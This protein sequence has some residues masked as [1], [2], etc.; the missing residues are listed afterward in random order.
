[1]SSS[2]GS[3]A[4]SRLTIGSVV[5]GR[6]EIVG[7]IGQ[8]GMGTVY[9]ARQIKLDK[10][11]ALKVLQS[12]R[13]LRDDDGNSH[14][15]FLR[16]ARVASAIHH[17]NVVDI[18]DFGDLEDGSTYYVMELL[19]GRDLASIL[20]EEGPLA[21]G[22]VRPLLRQVL[23][24]LGAAHR[25][26][27]IHRDVKPANIMVLDEPDEWG[28]PWVKV[29]D[30]GIARV[31]T[32]E[33]DSQ[34]LTGTS[35]LLGTAAY[36]GPELAK[37]ERADARTDLYALGIVAYQLLTGTVP[38]QAPNAFQ[39]LLR[40]MTDLPR[41]PRELEPSIPSEVEAFV[42]QSLEKDREHR[43][44]SAAEMAARL[45]EL[46]VDEASDAHRRGPIAARSSEPAGA[47]GVM[48]AA[49]QARQM[50]ELY[51]ARPPG[52]DARRDDGVATAK[53]VVLSGSSSAGSRR[54]PW[55]AILAGVGAVVAVVLWLV[56][57]A[58]DSRS[59]TTPPGSRDVAGP[60]D[61]EPPGAS[62]PAEVVAAS[63]ADA[64]AAGGTTGADEGASGASSHVPEASSGGT[65]EAGSGGTPEAGTGGDEGRGDEP[66]PSSEAEGPAKC[67]TPACLHKAAETRLRRAVR[68]R[69]RSLG[70]GEVV[71]VKLTIGTDGRVLMPRVLEPHDGTALGKCVVEEVAK[72]RFPPPSQLTPTQLRLKP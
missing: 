31:Q 3:L 43:F 15:R 24:A 9:E 71:T 19:K 56:L 27:V 32:A 20:K 46:D 40:H 16:E 13:A 38:F 53:T 70:S 58:D 72:G 59:G 39:V 4:F 41:P 61:A 8:G 26:G 45:D 2:S 67:R 54:V 25:Q 44:A 47:V 36:M 48:D 29:L 22:R 63:T 7:E 14:K 42:L 68:R 18:I 50:T 55:V 1:M 10:R 6:Y 69:C 62:S 37:G 57:G 12:E 49:R 34:T 52:A 64:G 21:W 66:E 11:V 60:I 65:P 5:E 28:R 23:S 35:E 51:T 33:G 30:F 17:R